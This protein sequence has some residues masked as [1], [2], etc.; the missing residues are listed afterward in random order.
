M[1]RRA[2]PLNPKLRHVIV[3]V[4]GGF[5]LRTY[6]GYVLKAFPT[7]EEA[8]AYYAWHCPADFD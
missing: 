5:E 6:L 1:M 8:R 2:P 7:L 4:T 3:P